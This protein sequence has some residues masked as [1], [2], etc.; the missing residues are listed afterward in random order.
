MVNQITRDTEADAGYMRVSDGKVCYTSPI[1]TGI[2]ADYDEN[3]GVVGI[4]VL[5]I[6]K[7]RSLD[8][9]A[10]LAKAQTLTGGRETKPTPRMSK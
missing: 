6:S 10:L 2:L 1:D 9:A 8:W 5:F 7:Q 3:G 4:E